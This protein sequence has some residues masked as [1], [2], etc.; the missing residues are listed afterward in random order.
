MNWQNP[1][2]Q[3]YQSWE[4]YI[5]SSNSHNFQTVVNTASYTFNRQTDPGLIEGGVTLNCSVAGQ[6]SSAISNFA[7][8][9]ILIP[10]QL[11]EL[12]NPTISYKRSMVVV[13][14][15]SGQVHLASVTLS[16]ACVSTVADS[17]GKYPRN[18]AFTSKNGTVTSI[19]LAFP[20]NYN[21]TATLS[22]TYV[23]ETTS[24]S[25]LTIET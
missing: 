18:N 12:Q 13:N 19:S 14:W 7:S 20:P 6:T 2:T 11:A 23:D 1:K 16:L 5:Q 3:T 24:S 17:K 22:G 25:K 21:C 15:K 10:T 8:I 9:N 4:V